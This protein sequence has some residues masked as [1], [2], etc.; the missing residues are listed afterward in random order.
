MRV[1]DWARGLLLGDRLEDKL[2]WPQALDLDATGPAL[3]GPPA[4]PG[5][6]AAWAFSAERQPFPALSE[7][8]DPRARGRMLH[9]FANHEL[10]AIELLALGLLRFPDAPRRFRQGL[11][12]TI[13]DEQVHLSLYLERMAALGVSQGQV[14]V[15][16]FFWDCVADVPT[17]LDLC[18]RLG[19]TFEQANL[20]WCIH[21][22]AALRQ[23]GDEQTAA[24]MDRVLDDEIGHVQH[25]LHWFRR[26]KDPGQ[27]DWDAFVS[28]VSLPLSPSRARGPFVDRG[29]RARAG[30]DEDFVDHLEV[31]S[32]SKGRPPTVWA[33][34]PDCEAEVR[35]PAHRSAPAVAALERDLAALPWVLAAP[36]DVVLVPRLPSLPWLRHLREAGFQPP[37]LAAEV[38]DRVV[39]GLSPWGWSPR[40]AARLG[41]LVSALPSLPDPAAFRKDLA[42]RL[43]PPP[44]GGTACSTWSEVERAAEELASRG[45]SPAVKPVL[46]TA[47]QGILRRVEQQAV[48]RLLATQPAVLVVPW[49]PRELD[50]S[51]HLDLEGGRARPRGFTVFQTTEGGSW[52]RSLAS[53]P[54][55]GTSGEL[56]RFLHGQHP[57]GMPG[58]AAQVADRV[59]ALLS[60]LGVRGPVG[61]DMLVGRLPDGQRVLHPV[62]ELNPRWT[63]G[64]V[65]LALRPRLAPGCVAWLSLVREPVGALQALDRDDKGR[66]RAGRL[67]LTDPAGAAIAAV[68]DVEPPGSR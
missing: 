42:A 60:P 54:D 57:R 9:V 38:G 31:W 49:L 52:R 25:G 23:V 18:V 68:L 56:L 5:R 6:P 15:H 51:L 30:L 59:A 63:M 53:P 48:L 65:A 24:V 64:R 41:P 10:L 2:S 37:E 50:L 39:G 4:A 34:N 58:L 7:L 27:S 14:P 43:A 61:V 55:L 20:D 11:V 1:Q 67:W 33:F 26:W 44:L 16:S 29:V 8:S 21:Y 35:D 62:V 28:L 3:V 12:A 46:S 13:R 47:G 32:R 40:M 22:G 17:P 66:L 45:F 19:L 36:H